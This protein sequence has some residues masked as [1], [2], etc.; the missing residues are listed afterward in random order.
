MHTQLWYHNRHVSAYIEM[1]KLAMYDK[2]AQGMENMLTEA[3]DISAI[4]SHIKSLKHFS[5][6]SSN[7]ILRV[8]RGDGKPSSSK[9]E[10]KLVFRSHFADQLGGSSSTFAVAHRSSLDSLHDLKTPLQGIGVSGVL[11]G[12]SG[13]ARCFRSASL[14]A[15]GEDRIRGVLS[16]RFPRV[17]ACLYYP[18]VFKATCLLSPPLQWRGGVLQELFKNKGSSFLPSGYRDIML[19]AVPVK[20]FTSHVRSLIVPVA[21]VLCGSSQFGSGLNGGETAFAHLY[22]RFFL[23]L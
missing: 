18:L 13:L 10:E 16:R 23:L 2:K 1:D 22:V 15:G 20:C 21:K 11:P 12:I 6:K 5:K 19:G 4:H 9:H 17:F 14:G 7:K 8:D 3:V